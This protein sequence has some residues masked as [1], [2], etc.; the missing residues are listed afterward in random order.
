MPTGRPFWH[1]PCGG[2]QDTPEEGS[3]TGND[4]QNM[5]RR[6]DEIID[7]IRLSAKNALT[8]AEKFSVIFVSIIKLLF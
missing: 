8:D 1:Y 7:G 2:P 6:D 4:A 5:V 3:G